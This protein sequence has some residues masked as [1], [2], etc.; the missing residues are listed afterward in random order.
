MPSLT[1]KSLTLNLP[2]RLGREE[3][4]RRLQNGIA[5]FRTQNAQQFAQVEDHWTGDHLDLR[6]VAMG[7]TVTGRVDVEPE[8]VRV[9]ID[10]PWLFA[11]LAEKIRG[12]IEQGATKLLEHQPPKK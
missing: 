8:Q 5:S 7:Q 11:M 3:A 9:E 10:L 6:L 1:R 12:Q 2:H 4:R